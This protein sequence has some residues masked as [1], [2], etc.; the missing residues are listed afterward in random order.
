MHDVAVGAHAYQPSA[1]QPSAC[2][3]SA[4]RPGLAW[5]GLQG[6]LEATGEQ[7]AAYKELAAADAVAAA[8][9]EQRTARLRQLQETLVQVG[10]AGPGAETGIAA[11]AGWQA[12]PQRYELGAT[13]HNAPRCHA[14]TSHRLP[15]V[16]WR[17]RIVANSGEWQRRNAALEAEKEAVLGHHTGLKAALSR[18]RAAQEARL[19]QMCVS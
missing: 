6:Y 15:A 16:Q 4:C 8:A 7:Q 11:H 9:I 18:F 3:P 13:S 14:H 19:K 2:Q 12:T 17:G 1:Y 10:G 5:P